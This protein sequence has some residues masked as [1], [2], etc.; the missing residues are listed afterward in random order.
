VIHQDTPN[1]YQVTENVQTL[2]GGARNMGINPTSH[3]V[4]IVSVKFEARCCQGYPD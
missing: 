2:Q 4:F 3:R 1:K